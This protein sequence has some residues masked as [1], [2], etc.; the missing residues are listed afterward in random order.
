MDANVTPIL[1]TVGD[2]LEDIVVHMQGAVRLT[3]DT[4][5]VVTRTRGGSAANVAAMAATIEGRARFIGKV[6]D[7]PIGARL[8]DD[9]AAVGVEAIAPREGRTGSVIVLVHP[10]G[11]RTMLTDRATSVALTHPKRRWLDGLHTLHVPAYSLVI[12]PLAT[13]AAALVEWAHDAGVTVSIDASSAAAVDHFGIDAFERVL[14][15]LAP[16]LVFCNEAE[17]SLLGPTLD[18]L[19]EQG[20]LLVVHGPTDATARGRGTTA[21]APAPTIANVTDTTGAGDA[22]AAGFLCAWA[23]V[24]DPERALAA[25]HRAAQTHIGGGRP[26]SGTRSPRRRAT[27]RPG[28]R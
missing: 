10:D 16:E 28:R 17:S 4:D 26:P 21:T 13:T 8:L 27:E 14:T 20:S 25:G 7:D 22:F 2:L 12:E 23:Q 19:A 11:E 15:G 18:R 5:A 9:L 24:H 6:G 1:G 3:T